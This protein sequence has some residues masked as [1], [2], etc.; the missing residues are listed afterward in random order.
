MRALGRLL[1]LSLAPSAAADIAAGTVLGASGWPSGPAPF[2]L[3]AGSLCVYHGGMALNDWADRKEDARGMR[4]RPIETGAIGAGAALGLAVVLLLV[5]P[6]LGALAAPRA[7]L[8]LAVV[9]LLAAAYDL[10]GRGPWRG[11][12]LLGA[13]RA[14]NLGAG[15]ALGLGTGAPG[16][17]HFAAAGLYGLYVFLVSRLARL[18]DAPAE[19]RAAA[20]PGRIVL[21]AALALGLCGCP[22]L[23]LAFPGWNAS[24]LAALAAAALAAAGAAGLVRAAR[25][26]PGPWSGG[27]VGAVVG[28]G[29][30]RLLIATA[31][32]SLQA[33]PAGAIV[34][35]L[36]LLGYRVSFLLRRVF[37]PT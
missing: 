13:C 21:L 27:E 3:I 31:S 2:L 6:L 24:G 20:R 34:A 19:E 33:G 29:L 37:P 12:A 30:R 22:S 9:A 5:G 18:E 4:G 36:V 11:P 17:I 32:L 14:G 15:L 35:V 7:G 23:L 25:A 1:R 8:V 26:H 16:P 28:M 10:A